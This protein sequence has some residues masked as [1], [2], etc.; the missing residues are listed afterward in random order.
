MIDRVRVVLLDRREIMH[1]EVAPAAPRHR[2]RPRHARSNQPS[3][4]ACDRAGATRGEDRV[5]A[6][7]SSK[8]LR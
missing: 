4:P 8:T 7:C 2:V 5:G 1:R 6:F 3:A